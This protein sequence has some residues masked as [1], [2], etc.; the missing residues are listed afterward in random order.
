MFE[1]VDTGIIGVDGSIHKHLKSDHGFVEFAETDDKICAHTWWCSGEGRAFLK[2]LEDVADEKKKILEIPNVVN[3]AL[4][5]ILK[6]NNYKKD[7]VPFAPDQGIMDL[8][9]VWVRR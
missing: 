9:D 6:D 8:V 4:L 3:G 5:K 2:Q 1:I 7:C